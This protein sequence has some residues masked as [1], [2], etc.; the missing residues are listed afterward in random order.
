MKWFSAPLIALLF[1]GFSSGLPLAL[2]ASTLAIRLT[3]SHIDKAGIG[4]FA[5][6][7]MPYAFKFLWAPLVDNLPFPLL[8][9]MLGRRRGW[10]LGAQCCLAGAICLL[11]LADPRLSPW[12]TACAALL[13]A[14]C[15]ATQ[16]VVIDAFR[17]EMLPVEQQG[18]AAAT[19]VLGYR[20]GMMASMAGA[21]YIDVALGGW[22]LTYFV[23]A[24]FIGIGMV[25]GILAG[26]PRYGMANVAPVHEHFFRRAVIAPFRE[27]TTRPEWLAI[28]AF[29]ALFKLPDAFIGLMSVAFYLEMGFDKI[30]LANVKFFWLGATIAGG[31]LGG[32][33]IPRMGLLRLLWTAAITQACANLLFIVLIYT[34]PDTPS[35]AVVVTADNLVSGLSSSVFVAY[36]SGLCNTRFTATQYAL[37]SSLASVARSFL[38]TPA[39]WVAQSLGWEKFFLFSCLLS[40]PGLTLLVYLRRKERQVTA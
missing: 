22:M 30:D 16:D 32:W 9:R 29:T 24:A 18:M 14:F 1:L 4:L 27:F 28:L 23:M 10:L 13:V 35:L 6:A 36:L 33:L 21:I 8:S 15:S 2:T 3:E 37:L 19:Y 11:A 40:L 17:V 20:I 38:S 26:E 34:G 39:G 25:A 5:A 31:F 7:T 12:L